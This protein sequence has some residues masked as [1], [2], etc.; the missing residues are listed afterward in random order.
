MTFERKNLRASPT[1]AYFL[2]FQCVNIVCPTEV[3]CFIQNR[4]LVSLI[5]GQIIY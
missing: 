4:C 2:S 5:T 3:M 1:P